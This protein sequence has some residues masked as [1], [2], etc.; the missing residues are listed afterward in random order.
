[1]PILEY[2]VREIPETFEN[3]SLEGGNNK[4]TIK[5]KIEKERKT[6]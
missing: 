5:S 6:Q 1:M 3:V 4:Y 2:L